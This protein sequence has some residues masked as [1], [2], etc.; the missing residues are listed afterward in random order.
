MVAVFLKPSESLKVETTKGELEILPNEY[1]K[2]KD[3]EKEAL[4]ISKEGVQKIED[5]FEATT[6]IVTEAAVLNNI[7]VKVRMRTP[8]GLVIERL[9]SANSKNLTNDIA[10]AY[11]LEMA[12]KRAWANCALEILRKNLIE[13]ETIPLLYS[14][15][16]E[17]E[18]EK[19][20]N[21]NV[22][23]KE[24]KEIEQGSNKEENKKYKKENKKENTQEKNIKNIEE[25]KTTES[26]LGQFILKTNRYRNGIT[27][28]ELL[29]K[30]PEYLKWLVNKANNLGGKYKE[31]Q[32]KAK[33]FLEEQNI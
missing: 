20:I 16:D 17:F 23:V 26:N 30:D 31:Y 4:V 25:N 12:F 11:P 29:Q 15:L 14:S 27:L 22:P 10:R 13:K 24:E 18:S 2:I 3:E 19:S 28:A 9:G 6:E 1:L 21:A 7:Y 33:A 32:E 5:F 8:E